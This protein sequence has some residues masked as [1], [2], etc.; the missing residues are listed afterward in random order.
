MGNRCEDLCSLLSRSTRPVCQCICNLVKR[1]MIGDTGRSKVQ[2]SL[3]IFS[4]EKSVLSNIH[5]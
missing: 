3:T 4:H 2:N 1:L 5:T